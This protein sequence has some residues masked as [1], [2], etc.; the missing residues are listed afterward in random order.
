MNCKYRGGRGRDPN[1]CFKPC[2]RTAPPSGKSWGRAGARAR[3][4]GTHWPRQPHSGAPPRTHVRGL[5]GVP[6]TG[7]SSPSCC[8]LSDPEELASPLRAS[9]F[10]PEGAACPL[11]VQAGAEQGTEDE[12][13]AKANSTANALAQAHTAF[14]QDAKN[15]CG[16]EVE[17]S[18][19]H[20]C[21]C[22]F[23]L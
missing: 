16:F 15:K 4:T 23:S 19:K 11:S 8:L 14:L 1:L 12:E 21:I 9:A 18:L 5:G 6:Q 7:L 22:K 10:A 20:S 17:P 3:G 13:I 2:C